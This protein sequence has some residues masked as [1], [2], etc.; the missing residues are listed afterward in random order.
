[1][2]KILITEHT[3]TEELHGN[4]LLL[5]SDFLGELFNDRVVVKEFITK[6][7]TNHY[8]LD[9]LVEFEFLRDV[10]LPKQ[11]A[12]K[13]NFISEEIFNPTVN[14]HDVRK[15]IENNAFIISKIYAHHNRSK[16]VSYVD[17][18]LAGRVM[19]N[20]QNWNLVTGN[21]KDFPDF[22]FDICQ[23]IL[24][25]R[26]DETYKPYYILKFNKDKF[27]TCRELL[28]KMKEK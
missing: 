4:Y 22:L 8:L 15:N 14:H 17:L 3:H 26:H 23:I 25:K 6:F 11:S 13:E 16:G 19:A 24:I 7:Q 10:F 1:M 12:L 20:Y 2:K 21:K 18:C 9:A 27:D 28:T 5:D